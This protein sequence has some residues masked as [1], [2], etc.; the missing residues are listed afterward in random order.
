MLVFACDLYSQITNDTI[1]LPEVLLEESKIK[2]FSLGINYEVFDPLL[3][4]LS[5]AS[6][7]SDHLTNY[8]NIYIKEYGALATPAFRGTSSSHT[9]ILWNGISINSIANGVVDFSSIN[10]LD[11][12]QIVSV[13]SGYSSAFGSGSIGG[14]IHLNA[15]NNFNNENELTYSRKIG[16]F[17]FK[18]NSIKFHQKFNNISIFGNASIIRDKNQFKYKNTSVAGSPYQTNNYGNKNV[19]ESTLNF[20]YKINNNHRLQANYWYNFTD[21][22]VPQNLSTSVTDA[23]QYDKNNR[24]LFTSL[25]DFNYFKIRFK[26]GYLK[27]NFRY[28]ELSKNIDSRYIAESYLSDLN[29]RLFRGK[30]IYNLGSN[31]NFNQINNNN[32]IN[33]IIEENQFS[34]YGS[35]EF[36]YNYIKFNSTLRKE[37]ESNYEVPILPSLSMEINF[38]NFNKIKARY[39]KNFRAPTFNDRFW[40]SSSSIGNED[41]SSE[42]SDNYE[43]GYN[44]ENNNYKF[45]I[46]FYSIKVKDWI[47][48]TENNSIWSPENI[49]SVWSRGLESKF[50]FNYKNSDIKLNYSLTNTTTQDALNPYDLSIGQ[51]LRYV[52]IHKGNLTISYSKNEIKYYLNSSYT[53][54]VITSYG[55]INNK[56]D[57]FIITSFGL[58]YNPKKLPLETELAIKNLMDLD[59]QTYQNYP[60]PGREFFLT[61]N[62]TI[63]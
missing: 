10:M 20:Q 30:E 50:K 27:E 24:F 41:L 26:Q 42:N 56:L 15:L 40:L 34:I 7:L 38:N 4:G 13:S 11:N 21:R 53:G 37:W 55:S 35:A 16:T 23:K 36:S 12:H 47:A 52:P 46:S 58:I 62:Y 51:Q 59:Y 14:S 2:E 17:G 39:S 6:T 48:W 57:D 33:N 54:E 22:E 28:T 9:N 5:S 45:K 44:Y 1:F 60:T 19:N 61:I 3:I 43:L 63:N 18:A 32:Y 8:S 31:F 25:N 49:K 29:I